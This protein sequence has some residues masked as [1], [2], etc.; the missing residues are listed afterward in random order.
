M[1]AFLREPA[2]EDAAELGRVHQQCWVETYQELVP[3][4]FWEHSTEARR[5]GMWERMLRRSEPGRRMVLAEVGTTVV[6]F[7]VVGAALTR[8]HPDAPAV[9]AVEVRMLY[10]RR[11]HHGSG[12]GQ[13]LLDAVLVD[14]E[15]AQL[16]VAEQNPRA[17]AFYRRNGFAPDGVRDL[18][19][20]RGT[21]LTAIR[22]LRPGSPSD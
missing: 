17:Q 12:I 6:G 8:E 18:N 21:D 11:S 1:T 4:E 22:M 2:P 9:D 3:P 15:A 10:L 20:H 19:A 7:A 14:G 16:W 5:I 13:Q